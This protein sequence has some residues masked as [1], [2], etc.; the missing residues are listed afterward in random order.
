[1]S[2]QTIVAGN[3]GETVT[4]HRKT[5]T[6]EQFLDKAAEKSVSNGRGSE[7]DFRYLE[8]ADTVVD[9]RNLENAEFNFSKFSNVTFSNCD[10][11][12]AEFKGAELHHVTF[13][14]CKI[15]RS[16]FDFA[17]MDEVSFTNCF[18]NSSEFDFAS[19]R[20]SFSACSMEGT[21]F[22][23]SDLELTLRQCNLCRAELNGS[24]MLHLHAE[25]SDFSRAELNDCTLAGEAKECVFS[26]AE[27]YGSDGTAFRF[28]GCKLRDISTNGAIGISE[29]DSDESDD[30]LDDELEKLFK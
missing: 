16:Y 13:S 19:G 8:V 27:F 2:K 24:S 6:A 4:I 7:N 28:L 3:G 17:Q 25:A 29:D 5:V 22:P 14:H 26:N 18:V 15:E 10:L 21:E 9:A 23:M 12:Y 20:V 1:M 30:S 11:S